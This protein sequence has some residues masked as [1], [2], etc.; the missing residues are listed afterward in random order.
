[1]ALEVLVE[2]FILFIFIDMDGRGGFGYAGHGNETI[3]LIFLQLP[4]L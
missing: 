2:K 1:M 4:G 3:R